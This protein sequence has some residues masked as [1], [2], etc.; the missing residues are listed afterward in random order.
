[1]RP[2]LFPSVLATSAVLAL[3][4]TC[5]AAQVPA[6][7]SRYTDPQAIDAAVRTFTGHATGEVGGAR[8]PADRRLRLAACDAPLETSWHG[9]TQSTVKVECNGPEPW[10]IFIATRPRPEAAETATIV[11]RGDPVTVMIRGRGFTVQQAGEALES[12]RIGEWIGVRTAR[13]AD[14]VR[15]RIERPGLAVIPVG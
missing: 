15:A 12:G 3:A 14:P 13:K 6:G 9:R 11:K 2:A 10:R 7:D 1:M 8:V 5:V 4:P